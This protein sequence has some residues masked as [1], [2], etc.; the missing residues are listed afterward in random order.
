[1]SNTPILPP[2]DLDA[3]RPMARRYEF[4]RHN[5]AG[6]RSIDPTFRL[7]PIPI[8]Y[9]ANIFQGSV[10][11]HLDAAIDAALLARKGE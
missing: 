3:L 6:V 7:P 11:Q 9:G 4:F 2:L 1:M 10:A 5:V 8:P